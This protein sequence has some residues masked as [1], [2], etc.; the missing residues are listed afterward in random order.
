LPGRY[1]ILNS[2]ILDIFVRLCRI[3]PPVL[4][5]NSYKIFL[6]QETYVT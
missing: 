5:S 2:R 3:N 6:Q 4:A 1:Q